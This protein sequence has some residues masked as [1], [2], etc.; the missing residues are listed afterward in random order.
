MA[1]LYIS[2]AHKSSG[3]TVVTTGLCA[4]IKKRG[5]AVQPFK[6]GPDYID[7]MWLGA[8]AG[9]PDIRAAIDG[10]LPAYV[11]SQISYVEGSLAISTIILPIQR[12]HVKCAPHLLAERMKPVGLCLREAGLGELVSYC[13]ARWE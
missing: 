11:A 6:K 9:C 3:K 7:P 13:Q 1:H 12:P 5:L 10:G 4:A 8:A 2:A